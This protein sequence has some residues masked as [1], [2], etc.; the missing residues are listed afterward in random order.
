MGAAFHSP[1]R[2]SAGGMEPDRATQRLVAFWPLGLGALVLM[3]LWLGPLPAMS[4]RAFSAHMTLHLGVA[5]VAAPMVAIGLNRARFGLAG[6]QPSLL[7]A[8][9]VSAFE[10]MVVWG[11]H[12]PALHEA[13]ALD[14]AGFVAQQLSFLAAGV[15][16]W[17]VS[18]AGGSRA[19]FGIGMFAMLLTFMHMTM[20]GVLLALAPDL[21]YA[22]ELCLGAFG[23]DRLDDQRLGGALMAVGGGLPYLIGGI[24]LAY[25]FIAD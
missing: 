18:F 22:P 12:A 25:R 1:E 16:I 13:A 14:D 8:F 10:M 21:L 5:V 17:M 4:R 11:W 6:A 9:V 20:L 19:A 15:G 3:L 24:V 7:T 2:L 23:L